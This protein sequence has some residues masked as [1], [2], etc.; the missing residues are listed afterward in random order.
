MI[1]RRV[2][3]TVGVVM[4]SLGIV[5]SSA[6]SGTV[7]AAQTT[8]VT[9]NALKVSPVR[10]D[11]TV[12]PGTT[13]VIDLF[14]QNLTDVP[15]TLHAAV[16]DFTASSGE[17][18]TPKVILDENKFA[19]SH[20]F[21]KFAKPISD[22]TLQAHELKNIKA[23]I[24]V[25]KDAAGGGYFGAVRFSPA[26]ANGDKNVNLT[27]SV[28]S[29]ILL[30]VNGTITE[31]LSVATF[32]VHKK[33][34]A[35]D[36]ADVPSTLFTSNKNLKVVM[37]F[38]NSG[39]VQ[40]APFGSITV[41]KGGNKVNQIQ[42]NN[43]DPRPLVLP[44]STRKFEA[45]LDKIGTFGKYTLEGSFGYGTSGQLLTS[46]VTIYVVPVFMIV[47]SVSIVLFL[48]LAVIFVPKMVRAYN[49]RVIK[50]ATRRR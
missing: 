19:P 5:V 39:N 21:K 17:D 30:R 47:L 45:N 4:I 33:P 18:G 27:A 28:G 13:K 29:L 42:V 31:Q 11:L 43:I 38:S 2:L 10:W 14:V 40:V 26:S 24:V 37:R 7:Y 12:D 16:N 50:R 9:G 6:W 46:K 20:S 35:K 41:K 49:K 22:F 34:T 44:D 15:V 1:R 48:V 36:P 23:T 3:A 25:P 8:N 32:E